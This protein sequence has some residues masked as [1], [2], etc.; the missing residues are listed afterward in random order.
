MG[1]GARGCTKSGLLGVYGVDFQGM[2]DH[3]E[4]GDDHLGERERGKEFCVFDVSLV[5]HSF[6]SF[7]SSRLISEASLTI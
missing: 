1:P 6:F 2:A 7:Q 5:R 3:G 4:L